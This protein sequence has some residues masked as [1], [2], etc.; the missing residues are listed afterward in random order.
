MNNQQQLGKAI[1][2]YESTAGHFPGF[3][4]A[5]PGYNYSSGTTAATISPSVGANSC[6][7]TLIARTSGRATANGRP[8]W[9]R[10]WA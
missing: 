10:C 5:I 1:L 9:A 8:Q 6:C 4:N 7:P 2:G 3:V